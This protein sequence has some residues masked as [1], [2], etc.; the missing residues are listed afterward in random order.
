MAGDRCPLTI[1]LLRENEATQSRSIRV[2]EGVQRCLLGGQC[3]TATEQTRTRKR[4][5]ELVLLQRCLEILPA[6]RWN[7]VG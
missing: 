6:L 5:R 3:K 1:V 2:P 7:G 4:E